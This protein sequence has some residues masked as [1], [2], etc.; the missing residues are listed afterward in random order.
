[1]TDFEEPP[2][3]RVR[4]E[5]A[6]FEEGVRVAVM[7]CCGFSFDAIHTDLDGE[8]YSCPSCCSERLEAENERLQAEIG[9]WVR[10]YAPDIVTYPSREDIRAVNE[11]PEFIIGRNATMQVIHEGLKAILDRKEARCPSSSA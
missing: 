9:Q 4:I 11:T 6:D 1:M 2:V 3:W 5:D 10:A 7:P 8:T